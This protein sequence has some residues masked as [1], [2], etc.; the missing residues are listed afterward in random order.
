MWNFKVIS[1][2]HLGCLCR[3]EIFFVV[4]VQRE[5]FEVTPTVVFHFGDLIFPQVMVM[6]PVV[7]ATTRSHLVRFFFM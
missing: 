6:A 2:F 3:A 5:F 4:A 1:L 7:S